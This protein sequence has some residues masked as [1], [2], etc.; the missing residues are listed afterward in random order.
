MSRVGA[1]VREFLVDIFK[2]IGLALVFG[3]L[4]WIQRRY[5]SR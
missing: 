4:V 2:W 1:A 3:L 5:F